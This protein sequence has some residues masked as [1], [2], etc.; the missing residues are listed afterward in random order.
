[1]CVFVDQAVE[2]TFS[3]DLLHVDVSYGAAVS[4]TFV[5][6][7]ALSDALVRPGRVVM[8]LVFDQDAAQMLLAEDKD[9]IQELAAQGAYQAF[10]D[11]VH[12]R[13]LDSA[14]Q[15]PGAGCV[16]DGVERGGEV[17]SAVADQEL[18]VLEPLVEGEGEVAGLLVQR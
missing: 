15:D 8:R 3:A 2:D 6:G 1:V 13:R 5:A 16:E 17:R 18:D 4:V 9:A 11:R 12:A 14:A 7:D 10:A